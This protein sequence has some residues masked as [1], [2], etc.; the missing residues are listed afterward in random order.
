MM[1]THTLTDFLVSDLLIGAIEKSPK[2]KATLSAELSL[3]L[4][5]TKA[6][7]E[8]FLTALNIKLFAIGALYPVPQTAQTGRS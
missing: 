2:R 4:A 1:D 7:F 6:R 5:A 8:P 3:I